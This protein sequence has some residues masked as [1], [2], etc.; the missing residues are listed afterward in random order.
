MLTDD[1]VRGEF[2]V[3]LIKGQA[4]K[5]ATTRLADKVAALTGIDQA[6]SRR[7]AGRFEVAEFR[8][9]FDRKNRK[10]IGRYDASVRGLDPYPESD[11]QL[12]GDP[13]GDTLVAPLT[14]ATVD[15]LTRKLSW[16]PDGSYELGNPKVMEAWDFGRSPP[17]SVSE[18]RQILATDRNMKLLV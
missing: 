2:L 5:E 6:V 4:D 18:L 14:S 13:S 12:S 11:F 7:L 1:Y 15:L 10:L 9:E 3:D 8:R 17:E 16:R